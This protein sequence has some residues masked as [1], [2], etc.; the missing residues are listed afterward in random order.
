[1]GSFIVGS[2]LSIRSSDINAQRRPHP[3]THGIAVRLSLTTNT[4]A[5]AKAPISPSP[6]VIGR[7]L[8]QQRWMR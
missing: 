1:M 2:R 5:P 7:L 4:S 6:V 3:K 8:T